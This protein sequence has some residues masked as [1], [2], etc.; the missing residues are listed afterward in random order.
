M[1]EDKRF[2][3]AMRAKLARI[4]WEVEVKDQDFGGIEARGAKYDE[5]RTEYQQWAAGIIRQLD[6][7]GVILSE[8]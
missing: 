6:K 8:K 5:V 7:H 1:T 4:M 2:E 3:A